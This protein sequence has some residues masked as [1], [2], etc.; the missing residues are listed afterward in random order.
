MAT[1]GQ[2]KM[3]GSGINPE[4]FKQDY[5]GFARAAE[6]QAQGVTNLGASIGGVIKDFGEA[7]KEQKKVDAYNKASAK[8]IEAAITLG[9]SYGIT[10]AE[11]T[12]RPFLEAYNDPSLSPIEKAALLDEGKG[13]IPNVFGRFDA[14]Q[15]NA[16]QMAQFN[17]RNAP[18]PRSVNLQQGTIT[19]TI[20]GEQYEVPTTFNPETGETRRLDGS[21]V[22]GSSQ[23]NV[24]DAG[25]NLVT[26]EPGSGVFLD[27]GSAENA[28]NP[29][30]GVSVDGEAGVLP[31]RDAITNAINLTG[32]RIDVSNVLPMPDGT[33]TTTV[34]PN[35]D[36][37][38]MVVAE[39]PSSMRL[40]PGAKSLKKPEVA[41]RAMTD[42][43]RITANLPAG[44]YMARFIG[45]KPSNIRQLTTPPDSLERLKENRMLKADDRI[46]AVI[47]STDKGGERLINMNEALSLLNSGDV[48]SGSLE[49]IK[50][51]AKRLFGMDVASEEQF[52]S[53]VGNL[54][55]EAIDLTKGAISDREMKF[56]REELAPGI[57]KSVDGNKK[58]IE[59]KI[60][61]AK[62]GLRINQ[63]ARDMLANNALPSDIESAI[64]KIQNEESLVPSDTI[65]QSTPEEP[66]SATDRLRAKASQPK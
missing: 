36:G 30:T 40:P 29:L 13:M 3:L 47:E 66:Q 7:K 52:N 45:D 14:K 55:M 57:N 65:D 16:I 46:S 18:T 61:A 9:G 5:S 27:Y 38:P 62:R 20:N 60:A 22:G 11:E 50:V 19:E 31:S 59:F 21:V 6:T 4:S 35:V 63:I 33:P 54:A 17:A 15:A 32:G 51:A 49:S 44:Q 1:Y 24:I 10:G 56:F 28:M 42:A 23:P 53:L 37:A 48:K 58:I 26:P 41:E 8:A 43:E 25:L 34:A 64:K 39:K 12:L 2:G